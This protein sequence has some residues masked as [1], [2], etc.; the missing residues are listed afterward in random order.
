MANYEVVNNLHSNA[1]NPE[2]DDLFIEGSSLNTL[3]HHSKILEAWA[4]AH[5]YVRFIEQYTMNTDALP[6]IRR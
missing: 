2:N 1:Q 4:Q 3:L 5:P 6:W